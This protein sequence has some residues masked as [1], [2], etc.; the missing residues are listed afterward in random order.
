LS[1][2]LQP[3][4][5]FDRPFPLSSSLNRAKKHN[6][7]EEFIE[8]QISRHWRMKSLRY[9]LEG[10]RTQQGDV[11]LNN[12]PAQRKTDTQTAQAVTAERRAVVVGR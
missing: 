2:I 4:I 6:L 1:V 7:I 12:R 5:V 8:M 11:Q 3:L 9:R 10:I